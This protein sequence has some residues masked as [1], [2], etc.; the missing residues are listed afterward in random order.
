MG[1]PPQSPLGY[2]QSPPPRQG[3][4]P[5]VWIAVVVAVLVLLSLGCC[6]ALAFGGGLLGALLSVVATPTP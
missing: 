1:M 6:C 4:N 2:Y 3:T 5:A